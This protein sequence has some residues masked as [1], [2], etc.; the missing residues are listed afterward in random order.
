MGTFDTADRLIILLAMLAGY[1]AGFMRGAAI[2]SS[3][4]N[5]SAE[6]RDNEN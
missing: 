6:V 4:Q 5:G 1:V 2:F 3:F